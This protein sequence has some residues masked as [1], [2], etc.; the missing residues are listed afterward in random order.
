MGVGG[1]TQRVTLE[2]PTTTRD[3]YGG[4]STT[5]TAKATVWASVF[6]TMGGQEMD[7]DR[8]VTVATL[9]IKTHYRTD[10][11]ESWRVLWGANYYRVR[12]VDNTDRRQR[13]TKIIA[14]KERAF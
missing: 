10:I 11:D 9:E 14:T 7:G 13:F 3:S 4:Q 8:V 6:Y 12:G 2:Y 5:W 1:M